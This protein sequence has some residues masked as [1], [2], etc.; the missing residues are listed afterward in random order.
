MVLQHQIY[1]TGNCNSGRSGST[2]LYKRDVFIP[3]TQK[4]YLEQHIL[5]KREAEVKR[6]AYWNETSEYYNKVSQQNE[7]YKDLMSQELYQSSKDANLK[8]KA[9]EKR[10]QNLLVRRNKLKTLYAKEKEAFERE[11]ESLPSKDNTLNDI[12]STREKL[13]KAKNEKMQKEAELKMLQ[14]WK[15]NNPRYREAERHRSNL[16]T[17]KILEQQMA[18]KKELDSAKKKEEEEIELLM[19]QEDIKRRDEQSKIEEDNKMKMLTL[20]KELENQMENLRTVEKEVTVWKRARAEQEE[21]QKQVE[22]CE[23][24]RRKTETLRASRELNSFQKRQHRLKLKMKAK[25]IQEDLEV[26]CQKLEEMEA[27]TRLQDDVYAE[28]KKKSVEEV[29]WM[30]SVLEQQQL[31]ERKREKELELM[32][33]EEAAKMWTKQEEV[34]ER[35]GKARKKLMDEVSTSWKKQHEERLKAAWLVEEEEL[36]R[37]DEIKAEVK[38]LN[39]YILDQEKERQRENLQLVD[40]WNDQ[41]EYKKFEKSKEMLSISEEDSRRREDEIRE[42]NKLARTLAGLTMNSTEKTA[43]FRRRKVKWFY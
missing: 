2:V 36:K 9:M 32:F 3:R 29:K 8:E 19:I 21:L 41:I 37:M 4:E 1:A 30:K 18:E 24:Q 34:W 33:A 10:Q 35:E 40:T 6:V 15:I 17:S 22:E 31:E 23:G 38:Q 26:D 25:Q 43:D 14:H 28:K 5:K 13:Q 11:V 27:I 42:E 39:Q 12:Q 20:R 7:R 16:M